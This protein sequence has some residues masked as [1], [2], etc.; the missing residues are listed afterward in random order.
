MIICPNCHIAPKIDVY[1]RD[2]TKCIIKCFNCGKENSNPIEDL[3]QTKS[4][5][6]KSFIPKCSRTKK[7]EN[8][9]PNAEKFCEKCGYY[10]CKVCSEIH[11]SAHEDD[12]EPHKLK[13]VNGIQIKKCKKHKNVIEKF[14]KTCQSEMCILCL[15]HEKHEI[16]K[17]NDIINSEQLK[18]INNN[19]NKAKKVVNE[20]YK[21]IKDK[22]INKITSEINNKISKL[23]SEIEENEIYLKN[24]VQKINDLYSKNIKINNN[25][26][27]L[28]KILINNY[29]NSF[30]DYNASLNLI[31]NSHFNF[32]ILKDYNINDAIAFFQSNFILDIKE[33]KKKI[34]C[35]RCNGKKEVE[36]SKEYREWVVKEYEVDTSKA[37]VYGFH[38]CPG[39]YV[40][41]K[42]SEWKSRGNI[43]C[44]L[45][46]G[47]GAIPDIYYEK[48]SKCFG[49]GYDSNEYIYRNLC[50]KCKGAG[51][52]I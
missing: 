30:N 1:T 10:F 35:M 50:K 26:I 20:I 2:R 5:Y 4:E 18:V 23:K 34:K 6:T 41:K 37:D 11:E 17:I 22:V 36:E 9:I 45:C 24:S 43:K 48:C 15:G 39:K 52:L 38:N 3:I 40:N 31:S 8:S 32:S 7:H 25:L 12:E 13:P 28:I 27:E 44:P 19:V 42:K 47:E 46:K 16:I 29:N 14:C 49:N 51:Y 33:T 21:E